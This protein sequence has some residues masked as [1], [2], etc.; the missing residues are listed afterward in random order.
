MQLGLNRKTDEVYYSPSYQYKAETLIQA[1][2]NPTNIISRTFDPEWAFSHGFSL[3]QFVK[4][5]TLCC[6]IENVFGVV[7]IILSR[8]YSKQFRSNLFILQQPKRVIGNCQ[9]DMLLMVI[10]IKYS[11][12]H[13]DL[14][15]DLLP[16]SP[17]FHVSMSRCLKLLSAPPY[18]SQNCPYASLVE[19][20]LQQFGIPPPELSCRIATH[21]AAKWPLY[22]WTL[23]SIPRLKLRCDTIATV[24]HFYSCPPPIRLALATCFWQVK[25]WGLAELVTN[26]FEKICLRPKLDKTFTDNKM[27]NTIL[28]LWALDNKKKKKQRWRQ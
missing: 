9:L 10:S 24:M 12:N 5:D 2:N 19:K 15:R 20:P 3:L 22:I 14:G 17:T 8:K 4:F 1:T 26:T 16:L 7:M 25:Q 28:N 27:A 13:L 11:Y 23:F 21:K 18:D 6:P